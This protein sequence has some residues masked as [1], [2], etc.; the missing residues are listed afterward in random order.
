MQAAA[1]KTEL[2]RVV[3]TAEKIIGCSLPSLE[4]IATAHYLSR[5]TDIIKDSTYPGHHL[6]DLLPS[7]RRYSSSRF[8]VSFFFPQE[9]CPLNKCHPLILL[10]IH[11]LLYF[12]LMCNIHYLFYV[13][14][15]IWFNIICFIQ[16]P[17][18]LCLHHRVANI[19]IYI[20]CTYTYIHTYICIWLRLRIKLIGNSSAELN[21]TP[22]QH[23]IG[24][25][26]G[27]CSFI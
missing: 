25:H 13:V 22:T 11:T 20:Y 26:R 2:Q 23:R 27:M 16:C 10:H 15:F 5:A 3:K 17:V 18:F 8:R 1:D 9:I 6:F 14:C 19:Y 12:T 4:D 24:E 7:G 21:H